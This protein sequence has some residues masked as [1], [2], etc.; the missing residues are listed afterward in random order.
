MAI[1]LF[2]A[3]ALLV[4]LVFVVL[5]VSVINLRDD[6]RSGRRTTDLLIASYGAEVSLADVSSALR[7]WLVHPSSDTGAELKQ[8]EST[9][10][11][12]LGTLQVL[13]SG[14]SERGRVMHVTAAIDGTSPT[15]PTRSPRADL[16]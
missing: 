4:V 8:A 9:L 11:G 2:T 15:T 1:A 3:V 13:A 16:P 6:T 12:Q 10:A 5:L 14:A 7:G